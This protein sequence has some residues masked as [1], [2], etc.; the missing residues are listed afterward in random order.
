MSTFEE[1]F[2]QRQTAGGFSTEDTLAAFLPL[3]RQT[4]AAHAAGDVA[5]LAGLAEVHVDDGRLWFEEAHVTAATNNLAVVRKFEQPAVRAVEILTESRRTTDLDEGREQIVDLRIGRRGEELTRPVYLPGYVGWEHEIGHHDPL[6]DVFSLGLVLASLACGL[7]LNVPEELESFVA[8]RG[9]L[10]ELNRTLHPVLARA[11]A[12]MTELDRHRR[13]QDLEALLRSLENYR[14]Q[15]VDWAF[16]P[17]LAEGFSRRDLK[18]KRQLVLARLQDRLFEISRQNRLLHFRATAHSVHL[19]QASVPLSFDVRS[20]R[21]DQILTWGESF[22]R[23]MSAGEPVSLN[24]YLNFAEAVYLPS[25]LDQIR[26]EARRDQTEFGFAQLRLA[27]CF[28]RWT[29]LKE[30]PPE[31]F[32]SPLVLLPVELTLKKGVRDTFWLQAATSEAEVNPVVRHQFK[33]LYDVELPE[34]IDLAVTN[35]KAFYE[36]LAAKAHASE[37]AVSVQL[38]ERPRIHVI[39]EKARRR[40]DL[41]RR[42]RRLAGRGVRSFLDLDYSYDPNNYHPLGLRIFSEKIRPPSTWLRTIIEGV[43]RQRR[44][45]V[46]EPQAAPPLEPAP[47]VAA[48]AIE[49]ER[50]LFTIEGEPEANPYSWEFDLCGVTLGNFK[51]RK[52]S[53]VRDYAALLESDAPNA[54]FDAIFSLAPRDVGGDAVETPPLDDR[55][56][57]VSCDPTQAGAI[58]E[59]RSGRSYVVQGPPG[60][61]K[62]QTITNLIADYVARGLRVLFVCEKRAAIDVVYLRLRQQGLDE[63]CSLIHDSQADK[64]AFVM[65]LKRTYEAFLASA[66]KRGKDCEKTRES[67]L[68]SLRQELGPL[69]QFSQAMQSPPERARVPL[70]SLLHRLVALDRRLPPLSPMERERMPFYAVWN[71]NGP[72]IERLAGALAEIQQDAVLARHPLRHLSAGLLRAERPIERVAEGLRKA[73]A[74]L[75]KLEAA[76]RRGGLPSEAIDTLDKA[77][78]L[79]EYAVSVEPL[80]QGKQTSLLDARSDASKRLAKRIKQYRAAEKELTQARQAAKGW[81]KKLPAADVPP[82]LA[83]ARHLEQSSFPFLKAS[84]WRLRAIIGTSY[85]FRWHVVRPSWRQLLELLAA[86][87]DAEALLDDAAGRAR[88]EFS[89][90]GDPRELF[91]LVERLRGESGEVAPA[92][93]PLRDRLLKAGADDAAVAALVAIR[94]LIDGFERELAAFFDGG[95]DLSFDELRR[96]LAAMGEALDDL[97][98]FMHCLAALAELPPALASALRDLPYDLPRLEAASAERSLDDAFRSDRSTARFTDAI[99]RRHVKGLDDLWGQWQETNAATVRDRVRR[100]FLEHVGTASVSATQLGADEKEFKKLY[101]TGRRELEHEF[102]KSIRFKSIRDLVGGSSGMVIRDLKPVWLMSPLSVSDTL[103]LDTSWFDVVIF[104]EASQITV[105]EAVPAIFRA[106]QAIVVGDEMQLPPT[107]FFSVRRDDGDERLLIEEGDEVVAYDL[108]SGSFLNHAARNLSSRMLGWHYR[109][110]SESLISFSNRAFYQG[111]LLTVPEER[112]PVAGGAE[113]R[114]AAAGDARRHADA[115]LQRPISFH[116]MEH[117]VYHQRRNAAEAEY[118]AHMVRELLAR[119]AGLS[120]GV[121]A[122][123]EAQQDEI[124]TALSRLAQ[125]DADFRGRL[126]AEYERDDDGQFVGLLVK[127]LE[128]I[129]GDERDVVILSVCYGHG[130][131]GRMLMNFGPINKS[132]GEKRLNVA[133]SRAK[134]HMALVASIGATDVTND[135]N[136]GANCLKNYLRYAAAVSM[137]DMA[138][139]ARVLGDLSGTHADQ[140]ARD[141]SSEDAVVAQLAAALR[142]GGWQVA[143]DVGQSHFRCD[144]A[145]F[146]PGDRA[147]ALGI[148]V[149]TDAYYRQRDVLERELMK[150][151]LLAAFGWRVA[152]V[153]TK[154]WHHDRDAVLARLELRLRGAAEE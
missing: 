14:D 51:Y 59:A 96:G 42:R 90:E 44:H 114:A 124:T 3:V 93:A 154:D 94:P 29:N 53:L 46:P 11:V 72:Q 138:T 149:D 86:Q 136:D 47:A 118:I 152:H 45:A 57:V 66:G 85:D 141:E 70:R 132:G 120:L 71:A 52:M 98:D 147:Y 75:A 27:V 81:V 88:D 49:Q 28:L 35:V 103:P 115:L 58:A 37:P 131:D 153:L 65:D 16:D 56:H 83:Q 9:N 125:D 123:S 17:L 119:E 13:P 143:F 69:E 26:L 148:L 137:G 48:E 107:D 151:K 1:F 129:Q 145:V 144:L 130:P 133:F 39:H 80:A 134:H 92:V 24:K 38:I 43:A 8:H 108:D 25:A 54:A 82:A 6:T 22:E 32:D 74:G 84:W 79:V 128:N 30:S 121:I 60:T 76:L 112:L 146:H 150:P 19:T 10:F 106:A 4:I 15:A 64:K 89:F 73:E 61:G 100:V 41:Y 40:L 55:F 78:Q 62:S 122:F 50:T 91:A 87:Y 142:A 116:F 101:N 95:R 67:V 135:Y 77:R 139:A 97:P 63:L 102:G 23:Q 36:F 34:T 99:R 105:E 33:Q 110:R 12:R 5:P 20:I 7:D 18:G 113:L 117:G 68:Q 127:N 111:R 126:E 104:D 109:S 140:R 2:R 31:R 21:T